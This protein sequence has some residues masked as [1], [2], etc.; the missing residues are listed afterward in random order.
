MESYGN[1]E[2]LK[3]EFPFGDLAVLTTQTMGL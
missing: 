3:L 1:N 2:V